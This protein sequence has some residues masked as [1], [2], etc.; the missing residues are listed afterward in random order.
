MAGEPMV[1]CRPCAG[2]F[3][4]LCQIDRVCQ[5]AERTGRIAI[6][7]TNYHCSRFF[8]DDFSR[9]FVSRQPNLILSPAR[10]AAL[11]DACAV[12]PE[13]VIGRVNSYIADFDMQDGYVEAQSRQR[14]TFDFDTVYAQP[15]LL[16]HAGGRSPGALAALARLRL[17]DRVADVLIER[18]QAIGQPY[19]AIHIRDTDYRANYRSTIGQLTQALSGPLFVASDNRAAVELVRSIY[20]NGEVF[21][22]ANLPEAPGKPIHIDA[23]RQEDQFPDNRDAIVDLVMLALSR[24]L[25]YFS[26]L[27]NPFGAEFSGFSLLADELRKAP[28][29]LNSLIARRDLGLERWLPVIRNF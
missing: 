26:L 13:G 19:S 11:F 8:R 29:V 27:P 21:S 14:L 25:F 5:Y 12:Y 9:Y 15:L 4:I 1:L 6:I 2:L 7:D 24:N 18:L 16:H 17:H 3:D 28:Y 23:D 20:R 10:H 22:F